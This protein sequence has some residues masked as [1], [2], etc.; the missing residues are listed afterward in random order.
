M[1]GATRP[2]Y[3]RMHDADNVAI[4]VNDGGLSAGAAFEDGL[5]LRDGEWLITSAEVAR[6]GLTYRFTAED[7]EKG[8][9]L[10]TW[11]TDA[12]LDGNGVAQPWRWLD[13]NGKDSLGVEQPYRWL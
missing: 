6:N 11:L 12:G 8:G 5:T 2:L 10:W 7:N 3:I 9:A 4:V 1:T 13:D